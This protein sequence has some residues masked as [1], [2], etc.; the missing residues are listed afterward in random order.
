MIF[1]SS[2]SIIVDNKGL[3]LAQ[4][5]HYTNSSETLSKQTQITMETVNSW[6][7]SFDIPRFAADGSAFERSNLGE[8]GEGARASNADIVMLR[9]VTLKH[10]ETVVAAGGLDWTIAIGVAKSEYFPFRAKWYY[11]LPSKFALLLTVH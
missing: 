2:G 4:P 8:F 6:F 11:F 10:G 9:A 3:T 5:I 1:D 7:G